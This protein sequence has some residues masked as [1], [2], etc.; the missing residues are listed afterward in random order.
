MYHKQHVSK[1]YQK[2]TCFGQIHLAQICG[3]GSSCMKF[4]IKKV[5]MFKDGVPQ[6]IPAQAPPEAPV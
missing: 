3:Q 2:Q 6:N 4:A 1:V 5:M